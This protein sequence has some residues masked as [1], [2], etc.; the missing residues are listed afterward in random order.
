MGC[1]GLVALA[2]ACAQVQP[3]KP[4]TVGVA[5]RSMNYSGKEVELSV[6]DP[7]DKSNS[8]GGDALN[9][10]S[11]GG[12]I[13]CFGIPASW[14]PG[15][16][17]IVK[18]TL[19]PDKKWHE[20]LVDVPPY[21]GGKAGEIW[22]AMHEDGRAEAVVSNFGPTRDEWPGRVKGR[23]VPSA[24]YALKV[25]N[26]ALKR[27]RKVLIGMQ[28]AYAGDISDLTPEQVQRLKDGIEISTLSDAPMDG[29]QS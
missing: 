2:A 14:H 17:V 20:Q 18:Y 3:G 29:A 5:V 27:E 1:A 28:E 11:T 16:Q 12:T 19:Y 22:L 26:E 10:Y 6:V 9:P 8:G 24:E 23:P 21:A 7:L 25:R 13:C 15:Y 4:K